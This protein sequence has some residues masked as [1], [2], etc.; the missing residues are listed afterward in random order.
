MEIYQV[1]LICLGISLIIIFSLL[2]FLAYRTYSLAFSKKFN[3]EPGKRVYVHSKDNRYVLYYEKD[4]IKSVPFKQVTIPSFDKTTLYAHFLKNKDNH[5]YI[6][7]S[8]GYRGEWEELSIP[9]RYLNE[10][11]N[12]NLLMIEQ[13][14]HGQSKYPITTFGDKESCD[15]LKWIEYLIKI[16]PKAQ[17]CLY[18]LSMGASIVMDACGFNLPS[19]VKC[20]IED[21]GFSSIKKEITHVASK[22]IKNKV[23]LKFSVSMVQLVAFIL[24]NFS[25]N[26]NYPVKNLKN[27]IT[28]ILMIHG[29][30]DRYVPTYMLEENYSAVKENVYKEK[31]IFPEASHALSCRVDFPKY[32]EIV[33]NF[34]HKF[35][36]DK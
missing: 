15:L 36:K 27:S 35:I 34:L 23:K 4:W 2:F 1:L 32:M 22:K 3:P 14:G 8:H 17:I 11:E 13:R 24:H 6:I 31:H 10:K 5:K 25:F 29:G 9:C 18:G 30:Q 19:N 16:D 12:Y 21:C 20:A 7:S 33:T 26:R 28:P